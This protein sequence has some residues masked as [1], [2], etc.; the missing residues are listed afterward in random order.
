M[1]LNSTANAWSSIRRMP[2]QATILIGAMY[3]RHEE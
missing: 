3:G 1:S 2:I